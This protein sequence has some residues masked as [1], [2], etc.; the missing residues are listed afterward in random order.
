MGLEKRNNGAQ[1]YFYRC[2]RRSSDGQPRKEYI[3]SGELARLIA[4]GHELRRAIREDERAAERDELENIEEIIAAV[5]QTCEVVDVLARA[6]LIAAG[7]HYRGGE[8]RRRRIARS[9]P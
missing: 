9:I 3:A 2:R 6:H 8:W 5:L 4:Q 7:F 1:V